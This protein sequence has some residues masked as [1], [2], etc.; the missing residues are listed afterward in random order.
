MELTPR[1][2]KIL[3]L[4]VSSYVKTGEPVGSKHIADEIG[5]SSATVRN[6][7][8]ELFD[9]GLLAQPHT[10]AG[11]I[12]SKMGYRY[13]I[14]SFMEPEPIPPLIKGY[15]DS[16]IETGAFDREKLLIKA[17]EAL[18][19]VTKFT[20][21][22]STPSGKKASITAVQFVQISRRT[23]MLILMSS[24]G[25]MKTKVFHCDFDLSPEI[26]RIFFRVFNESV[27][28][29]YLLEI[30]PA[31]IQSLGISFGELA[32][33]MSSALLAL[34][35][36]V[37]ES[38]KTDI[39]VSGHMNLLFYPEFSPSTVRHINNILEEPDEGISL[40][41]G[42]SNKVSILLGHE[43]GQNALENSA[44]ISG[45]YLINGQDAGGIGVIG[46][47]RMNYPIVTSCVSYINQTVG[48]QLTILMKED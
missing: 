43:T 46:P 26:M 27:T 4:V 40:L 28:G 36:A 16:Y 29:K 23:A 19:A 24:A 32:M 37:N 41:F 31:T 9:L 39:I 35:E 18:S 5:V 6:E 1:K 21:L 20:A 33:L 12:P 7:M 34:L 8:A 15:L 30:T 47:M 2:Q 25:T 3:A 45:R 17:T 42:R 14:D 10:S 22:S 11:R 38:V 48:K 13:Y 44:V